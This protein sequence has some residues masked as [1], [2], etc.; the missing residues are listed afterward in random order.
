LSGTNSDS[1]RLAPRSGVGPMDGTNNPRPPRQPGFLSVASFWLGHAERTLP[2][3]PVP[4]PSGHRL[5]RCSLRRPSSAGD[6][7]VWNLLSSRRLPPRGR[8]VLWMTPNPSK[9][10]HPHRYPPPLLYAP[11]FPWP[12]SHPIPPLLPSRNKVTFTPLPRRKP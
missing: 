1:Q 9:Q 10:R 7:F 8:A 3:A 6:K 11:I 12:T 5:C 2:S 4:R